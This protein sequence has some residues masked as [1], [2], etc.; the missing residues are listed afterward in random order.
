MIRRQTPSIRIYR[1]DLID[2][3]A[4]QIGQAGAV[5]EVFVAGSPC[6]VEADAFLSV[7]ALYRHGQSPFEDGE[8][9]DLSSLDRGEHVVNGLCIEWPCK[10]SRHEHAAGLQNATQLQSQF[11]MGVRKR[12]RR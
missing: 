7:I 1:A 10:N 9:P 12:D 11:S 8:A 4:R 3:P 2:R 6:I 5:T